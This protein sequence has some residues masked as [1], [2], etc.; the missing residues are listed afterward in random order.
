MKILNLSLIG[1]LLC[2]TSVRAEPIQGLGAHAGFN[3]AD[4]ATDVMTPTGSTLGLVAG[5]TYDYMFSQDLYLVPGFQLSQR[6]YGFKVGLTDVNL[7]ITYLE[8]PIQFQARFRDPDSNLIPFFSGG[9]N[10][11]FKL[12]TS[13]STNLGNCTVYDDGVVKS[14][15]MGLEVGGGILLPLETGSLTFQL[16]YHLGL[17]KVSSD[18]TNPRH[19]GVLF[20]AGY[21]F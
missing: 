19:R 18:S 5:G 9:P 15:V 12:G 4:V 8:L 7:K 1:F 20:Q 16:R 14:M 6:G 2:S 21:L 17:T 10:L 13:C 3:V 11:G